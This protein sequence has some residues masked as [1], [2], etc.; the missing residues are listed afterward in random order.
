[1]PSVNRIDLRSH[2]KL[3]GESEVVAIALL[4]YA[5]PAMNLPGFI[6]WLSQYLELAENTPLV[7]P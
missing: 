6:C 1:M 2:L 5:W 3:K 4:C 7:P